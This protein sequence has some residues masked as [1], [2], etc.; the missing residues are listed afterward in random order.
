MYGGRGKGA[1][2]VKTILIFNVDVN[3]HVYLQPLYS[4][5]RDP[6]QLVDVR[7]HSE[8]MAFQTYD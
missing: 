8:T 3:V 1:L 4:Q 2:V 7:I 5:I 6:R